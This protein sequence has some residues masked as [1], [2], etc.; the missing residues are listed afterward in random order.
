MAQQGHRVQ[1]VEHALAHLHRAVEQQRDRVAEPGQVRQLARREPVRVGRAR[2]QAEPGRIH[3]VSLDHL[4]RERRRPDRQGR[5]VVEDGPQQLPVGPAAGTEVPSVD[6]LHGD[7]GRHP[8][9]VRGPQRGQPGGVGELGVQHVERAAAVLLDDGSARWRRRRPRNRP[10]R[11]TAPAAPRL[12][13]TATSSTP[14]GTRRGVGR[15]V[16]RRPGA[17]PPASPRARTAP[18]GA[19]GSPRRRSSRRP[20]ASSA[21]T[22]NTP[23]PRRPCRFPADRDSRGRGAP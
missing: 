15:T 1:Q 20:S 13:S 22:R 6:P 8:D 3:A 10:A 18:A 2:D 9:P 11:R 14:S 16:R 5:G 19:P 21:A 23:S 12:A 17:A 4:G 7:H